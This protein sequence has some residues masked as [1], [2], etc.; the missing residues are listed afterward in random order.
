MPLDTQPRSQPVSV[1]AVISS[2]IALASY[3]DS[4]GDNGIR[5]EML[6]FPRIT[7]STSGRTASSHI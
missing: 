4:M 1:D 5:L 3:L 6:K 7:V 2:W